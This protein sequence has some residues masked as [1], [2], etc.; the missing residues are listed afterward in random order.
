MRCVITANDEQGKSH[1]HLD[2][3]TAPHQLLWSADRER[4]LGYPP[5][6]KGISLQLPL[7][8]TQV[9]VTELPPDAVMDAIY[10]QG[11]PLHDAHGFHR[12]DTVDYVV[13]LDGPLTLVL[14]DGEV[15]LQA[16]DCVVQRNTRHAW[17]NRTQRPVRMLAIMIGIR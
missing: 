12:I 14:D 4:P 17:R 5:A 11:I 10:R 3:E 16:G 13:L 6:G 9:A 1:I 2:E 15:E 7:G 8:A